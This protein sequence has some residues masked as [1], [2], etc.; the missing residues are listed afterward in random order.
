M[1]LLIRMEAQ[2]RREDLGHF[3]LLGMLAW[4]LIPSPDVM[5]ENCQNHLAKYWVSFPSCRD[6]ARVWG[7]SHP[8]KFGGFLFLFFLAYSF[9]SLKVS[10]AWF[11]FGR[12]AEKSPRRSW[13]Q[14][15]VLKKRSSWEFPLWR[16]G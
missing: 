11:A 10:N 16:S 4:T 13:K 2:R 1:C 7:L 5:A 15:L 3:R 12:T 14:T 8:L 6:G 9:S